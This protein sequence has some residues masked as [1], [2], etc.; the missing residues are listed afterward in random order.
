MLH[1]LLQLFD[2]LIRDS[3]YFDY[4]S[5]NIL[6]LRLYR[7]M[8]ID[9]VHVLS[10]EDFLNAKLDSLSY[11]MYR[12]YLNRK[13]QVSGNQGIIPTISVPVNFPIGLG[14][15]GGNEA[16]IDL[17]GRQTIEFGGSRNTQIGPQFGAGATFPQLQMKQTLRVNLKGTVGKK[18]HVEIDHDSEEIDQTKNKVRLYYKGEEDEVF[19]LIEFGDASNLSFPSTRFSALPLTSSGSLFGIRANLQF[20]G[21]KSVVL[22][23]TEKGKAETQTITLNAQTSIDTIY[24]KDFKRNT[25][26]YL[27]ETDSIVLLRVFVDDNNPQNDQ[28]LGARPAKACFEADITSLCQVGNFHEIYRDSGYIYWNGNVIEMLDYIQDDYKIAVYYRTLS[29]KTVGDVSL[30]RDTMILKIVKL[31]NQTYVDENSSPEERILWDMNLKNVYYIGF[32]STITGLNMVIYKDTT[33]V[34]L[35]GE[36]GKTYLQILKLDNNGDNIVDASYLGPDGRYYAILSRGYVFFPDP[37]PFAIDELQYRDTVIYTTFNLIGDQGKK[38]FM[39]VQ[40]TKT[41]KTVQL[42]YDARNVR[43]IV[44]GQELQEGVDYTVN[45]YTGELT[46]KRYI[47]PNANI[48]ITYETGSLFQ[49]GKRTIL[50]IR[51]DYWFSDNLRIGNSILSRSKTSGDPNPVVN[52]ESNRTQMVEFDVEFSVQPEFVDKLLYRLPGYRS[53]RPS[54]LSLKAEYTQSFPIISTD[55]FA[56]I[57]DMETID[58]PL[59]IGVSPKLWKYGSVPL[60]NNLQPFDTTFYASGL[61]W[62]AGTALKKA[63]YPNIEGLE[64]NRVQSTLVVEFSPKVPQSSENWFSLMTLID[65]SGYDLSQVKFIEII[66]RSTEDVIVGIDVGYDISEDRIYRDRY[67]NIKGYNG[68]L[69]SEDVDG[70][71]E[72]DKN[73]TLNEDVGL[74]GVA[75]DDAAGVPGDDG[76]DDYNTFTNPK[77]TENNGILD[78]EGLINCKNLNTNNNYVSYVLDMSFEQPVYTT[79]SGWRFYRIPF[80]KP[81]TTVGN[82]NLYRARYI[83][84]W[85]KGFGNQGKLEIASLILKSNKWL[86]SAD[87]QEDESFGVSYVSYKRNPEYSPPEWAKRRLR[88]ID[89]GFEDE[90]SLAINYINIKP[91]K[92]YT[93]FRFAPRPHDLTFYRKIAMFVRPSVHTLPPY[94]KI[95]FRF[96]KD[97]LNYYFKEF[98]ITSSDWQEIF[99]DLIQLTNFKKRM[100]EVLGDTMDYTKEYR[101]GDI[102]FKGAPSLLDV[103]FYSFTIVNTSSQNITGTIWIDELRAVEPN[104]VNGY[105]TYID[106]S[107]N[108]GDFLSMNINYDRQIAGFKSLMDDKPTNDNRSNLNMSYNMDLG[109]FFPS[110]WNMSIPISYTVSKS[111]SYPKYK[112][113]TDLLVEEDK[114]IY[115]SFSERRSFSASYRKGASNNRL[116]KYLLD[117]ISL[118]YSTSWTS[119]KDFTKTDTS[120]SYSLSGSYSLSPIITNP[121]KIFGKPFYYL[122]RNV[123]FNVSYNQSFSKSINF[124]NNTEVITPTKDL[125]YGGGITYSPINNISFSYNRNRKYDFIRRKFLN[126]QESFGSGLN[127]TFLSIVSNNLSWSSAYSENALSD[128]DTSKLYN[129]SQTTTINYNLSTRGVFSK[130]RWLSDPSMNLS[131]TRSTSVSNVLPNFPYRFRLGFAFPEQDSFMTWNEGYTLSANQSVNSSFFSLN[132]STSMSSNT[133]YTTVVQRNNNYTLPSL[134][135]NLYMDRFLP[136]ALRNI[137]TAPS[138]NGSYSR[139]V[140]RTV[141]VNPDGTTDLTETVSEDLSPMFSISFGLRDGTSIS[142]SRNTSRR[143]S[144][145]KGA[146]FLTSIYEMDGFNLSISR[147]FT[148]SD[149]FFLVSNLRSNLTV[150]FNLSITNNKQITILPDGFVNTD[151]DNY[152]RTIS[153]EGSYSFNR[154]VNARFTISNS[155]SISRISGIGNSNFT[156]MFY[157]EF[158]F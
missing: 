11:E 31:E 90:G 74:D 105:A 46:F 28:D 104:S 96:G 26:F 29:G 156:V 42:P 111:E 135:Y 12:D 145:T 120:R 91:N 85:V 75:G 123:N 87:L 35:D 99:V 79:D 139:N 137:I 113:G 18:L 58:E 97:S 143:I 64:A 77:G 71:C 63:I 47:D 57:D 107:F 30:N 124:L 41:S 14:F 76:N 67:G 126:F 153:L 27:N 158:T 117:P 101:E 146:T 69:D 148:P 60:D 138:V 49:Y 149:N 89:G 9:T 92:P 19:Q 51:N 37:K 45:Y 23:A 118:S 121:P 1:L 136:S 62:Y 40:A 81:T 141:S 39:V 132:F 144:I 152:S 119:S 108:A 66:L 34:P 78:S 8:V 116:M 21:L 73:E 103:R 2:P 142:L 59:D 25:F 48:Q 86:V 109:K 130:I 134:S 20:G 114:D 82:P 44:N 93:T 131:Y 3:L 4:N 110:S 157:V 112:T 55:G 10:F 50:G 54:N 16:S 80:D 95:I 83:R 151:T 155:R 88:A 43:V 22:L 38:Y 52:E 72:L 36:N 5:G 133:S 154:N 17:S 61:N 125:D 15:L 106:L 7:N 102:G 128:A 147:I 56:F 115:G 100:L 122:P 65:K 13:S 127:F 33:P 129:V 24:A 98:N 94:P 6:V 70:D 84:I 53:G 32:D 150:S 68:K 140:S